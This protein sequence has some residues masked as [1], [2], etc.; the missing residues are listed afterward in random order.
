MELS[1]TALWDLVATDPK[2][3]TTEIRRGEI[4]RI[5]PQPEV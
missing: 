3:A 2:R 5:Y 1:S 4:D